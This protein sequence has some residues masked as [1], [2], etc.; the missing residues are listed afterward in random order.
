M[1]DGQIARL[2]LFN[3]NYFGPNGKF[4]YGENFAE[5]FITM[6]AEVAD[7]MIAGLSKA[8]ALAL[9][10]WND[11]EQSKHYVYY[12]RMITS[13]HLRLNAADYE[14]LFPEGSTI[15]T[16]CADVVEAPNKEVEPI[17]ITALADSLLKPAN[18]ALQII[19]LDIWP[20][21]GPINY[22]LSTETNGQHNDALTGVISA[23]FRPTRYDILYR[24]PP[25]TQTSASVDPTPA[26][27]SSINNTFLPSSYHT[28]APIVPEAFNAT[29]SS[30]KASRESRPLPPPP[31]ARIIAPLPA[32][33]LLLPVKTKTGATFG[34]DSVTP[35]VAG[36]SS[37]IRFTQ[38][39][40]RY[41]M[42]GVSPNLQTAAFRNTISNQAHFGNAL[43][44][45]DQWSP[46]KDSKSW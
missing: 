45:P 42:V 8:F 29:T 4:D 22:H 41:D 16:Y 46:D 31:P 24:V 30:C 12:M 25:P 27:T 10:R 5:T 44:Q 37:S 43:F 35:R 36:P 17:G 1:F 40:L 9:E 32:S 23:L 13:M 39:Q 6:L 7:A 11:A 33:T 14:A 19:Y 15:V 21:S 2:I 28:W 3:R 26:L 38:M 18:L 34:L 20:E